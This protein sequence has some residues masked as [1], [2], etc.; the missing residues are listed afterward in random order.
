LYYVGLSP[1]M[2]LL[3]KFNM[4]FPVKPAS[5]VKNTLL[6]K[7]ESAAYCQR[8]HRQNSWLGQKSYCWYRYSYCSPHHSHVQHI[9]SSLYTM[10]MV[11]R[12]SSECLSLPFHINCSCCPPCFVVNH[13]RSNSTGLTDVAINDVKCVWMWKSQLRIPVCSQPYSF[14]TITIGFAELIACQ[15]ILG[16]HNWPS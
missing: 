13:R 3:W 10:N 14:C 8:N 5:L 6:L 7:R 16:V 15:C 2:C 1:Q 4:L 11:Q 9:F 12:F